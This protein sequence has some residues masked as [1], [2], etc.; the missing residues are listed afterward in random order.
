MDFTGYIRGLAKDFGTKKWLLTLEMDEETALES[1]QDRFGQETKLQ[2]HIAKW[3]KKRSLDANSY[4]WALL[5]RM[6]AAQ[7]TTKE[8]LYEMYLRENR[9]YYK[10]DNGYVVVTVPA[11]TDMTKIAGHWQYS[12]TSSDGKFK[13]YTMLKGSS[14]MDTKEMSELLESIVK[15]AKEL[16]IPTETDYEHQ[17]MLEEW[18]R[19]Y[20]KKKARL[21]P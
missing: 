12:F 1:L 11:R 15:G 14:D 21:S 7:D 9:L 4:M 6:A 17:V 20:E 2:V 3:R 16:G 13:A 5:T 10:D 8:E 19:Q 18:G